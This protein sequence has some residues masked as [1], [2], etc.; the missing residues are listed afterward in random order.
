MK[1]AAMAAL[2]LAGLNSVA[3]DASQAVFSAPNVNAATFTPVGALD[4]LSE[5]SFTTLAHPEFPQYSVRMKKSNFCDEG[6]G[7]VTGHLSPKTTLSLRLIA[8]TLATSISKRATCSFTS[9]RVE[10]S[11]Q[12]RCDSLDQWR[13]APYP[14]RF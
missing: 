11:G 12:G 1:T 3:A 7:C 8:R 6:V 2:L 9:S 5:S 10:Q 14:P 13:Y 4:V